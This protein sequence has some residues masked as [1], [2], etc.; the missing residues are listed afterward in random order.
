[1]KELINKLKP[2]SGFAHFLHIAL[3]LLLPVMLL[4][5]ARIRFYQ[6]GFLLLLLS[7]WRIFAVRPRHWPVHFR[8]NAVDLMVGIS[9]LVFM[10]HSDTGAWEL[11]WAVAYG[12]WLLFGKPLTTMLGVAIQALIGQTMALM[13]LF[14]AWGTAPLALLVGASWLICYL[15]ARH[16][17]TSFEEPYGSLYSHIW[18]YFAA[19]LTWILVHWLLFYGAI[20]QPTLILT[21]LA[22][23]LGSLY[24]LSETDRLQTVHRRQFVVSMVAVIVAVLLLSDWS[25]KIF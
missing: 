1:M 14:L 3:N 8:M 21:V 6:L 5:L 22:I 7:K 17:F 11:V 23:G 13:A 12:L 16:F 24:Y 15:A 10:M 18:G 25:S 4:V 19:A 20:A 2:A 9:I